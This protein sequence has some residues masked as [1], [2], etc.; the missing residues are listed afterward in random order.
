MHVYPGS[1]IYV[2]FAV[3]LCS[4]Y[5]NTLLANLNARGYIRGEMTSQ[6]VDLQLSGS[7]HFKTNPRET[8]STSVPGG[9]SR[10]KLVE[11]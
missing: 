4:V 8:T 11:L 3:P 10:S 6:N 1:A 7:C 2:V 5:T 9:F